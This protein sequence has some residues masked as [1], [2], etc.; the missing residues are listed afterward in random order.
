MKEITIELES[1]NELWSLFD[2][3]SDYI[4]IHKFN[5]NEVIEWWK[6]DIKIKP[7]FGFKNLSV[8]NMKF[9]LQ[10]D[11]NGLKE[12]LKLQTRQLSIYQF[13]K[14]VPDTLCIETLPEESLLDIL[15]KNG[16]KHK[17][18]IDYEFVTIYSFDEKFM[19]TIIKNKK[20]GYNKV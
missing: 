8:R 9:D 5:P 14:P 16:L 13:D 19:E 11:L 2:K 6:S 20:T 1:Q 18:S 12:I 3:K 17:Y 7:D 15:K 4:F 10:T